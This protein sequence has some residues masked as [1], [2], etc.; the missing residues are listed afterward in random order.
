MGKFTGVH[1]VPTAGKGFGQRGYLRRVA[2]SKKG[3]ET[4]RAEV[5]KVIWVL[6]KLCKR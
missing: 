2:S 3:R 6:L 4:Y 5:M 1:S